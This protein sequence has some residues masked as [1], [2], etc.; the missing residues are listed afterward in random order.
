MFAASL[1]KAASYLTDP[2]CNAHALYRTLDVL[3]AQNPDTSSLYKTAQK[4]GLWMKI[5]GWG[6]LGLFTSLPAMALRHL[7]AVSQSE[8]FLFEEGEAAPKELPESRSFSLL[9]WNICCVGGGYS[10]SDGGVSH[11]TFRIDRIIDAIAREDADVNCLYETFDTSSAFYLCEKLKERGYSRFYYNI[12]PKVVGVSS[13]I[14]V[15]SKYRIQNPAFT[16]YPEETLVGR[17]KNAAKGIFSF[18]LE[19]QG[20]L[21]A[22]IHSTHLQH[23]EAPE[24]PTEEERV[25]RARQ[26][27][28]LAARVNAVRDRCIVATGDLNL[29]DEEYES[30]SWAGYFQKK[31]CFFGRKTWGGDAFCAELMG[32]QVS[33]PLNLDHTML[34]K[35][36]ARSIF[37][38]LVSTGYNPTAL[39]EE[40]L[41]DHAGLFSEIAL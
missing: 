35:G 39:R 28:I 30:S 25:A 26:M 36:T 15:A 6:A 32:K 19:S 37:T 41:S 23:S 8:P 5:A 1:F 20:E 38:M 16:A 24:F 40:A 17:T 2:I 13:G 22:R 7:G 33:G 4:I 21:F 31:N 12:G 18:D 34:A 9:S 27:E 11:W 10:I 3:D 14:F 29:D